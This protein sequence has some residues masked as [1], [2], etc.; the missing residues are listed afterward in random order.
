M[1]TTL[2]T[3]LDTG[4]RALVPL[5]GRYGMTR[6]VFRRD[7]RNG[8]LVPTHG[9]VFDLRVAWFDK[10][11]GVVRDFAVYE[12]FVQ[13]AL[14]F[15]PR[16]SL[17]LLAAGGST[18]QENSLSNLFDVG[19]LFR[20]SS[21]SRGQLLGN[22]YYLGSAYLRRAFSAESL[23]MFAKFYGM[24]GYEVGRAWYPGGPAT[25]RQDGV[26]GILGATRFGLVFFGASVG[27]QG[28]MKV[29]FRIGRAF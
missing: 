28:A 26:V 12:G 17:A 2:D 7:S 18:V 14:A 11:P 21:L 24:F 4:A 25:P 29:L 20:V 10:Y 16:Y 3:T 5:S 19:G 15:N 8:P 1:E 23:S 27:D 13:K 22:N 9:T 6:A